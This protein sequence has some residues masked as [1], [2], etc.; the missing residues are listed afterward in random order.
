MFLLLSPEVIPPPS[1][2]QTTLVASDITLEYR[3]I[4]GVKKTGI[5]DEVIMNTLEHLEAENFE[6]KERLKQ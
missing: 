3:S 4:S 1:P 2:A 5:S 6:V